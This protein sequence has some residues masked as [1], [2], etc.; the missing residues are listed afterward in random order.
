[1]NVFLFYKKIINHGGA[2]NLLLNHYLDLKKKGNQV[3]ILTYQNHLFKDNKISKDIITVKNI[4]GLIFFLKKFKDKVFICHSGYI[5][6]FFLTLFDKI[7]YSIFLH[8]PTLL[9][10]NETDKFALNNLRKFE[11]DIKL[12]IFKEN[13][14]LYK[15][16]KKKFNLFEK[17]Y[18]NLRYLISRFIIKN[19]NAIFVLSQASKIE[20]KI[21]YDKEAYF[22]RGALKN[23][24]I[25]SEKKFNE[26]NQNLYFCIVS[27][28]DINKRI[29]V[30]LRAIKNSNYHER[31]FLDIF[32]KG[33][34]LEDI[35]KSIKILNLEKNVKYKGFLNEKDKLNTISKYNYFVCLD[36]ADF[37]ISSYES[38]KACTPVILTTETS[39]D[40]DFEGL[41]CL[42]YCAPQ[43]KKI[44]NQIDMLFEENKKMINWKLVEKQLI[45]VT[46]E[47]Y[48]KQINIHAL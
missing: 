28:L 47:N 20:K 27:R 7:K 37:R 33:P 40:K 44:I 2:E 4:F 29:K 19:A 30:F 39:P 15:K 26:N 1:M 31:I 42:I 41:N 43:K 13:M 45:N 5:E 6:I 14:K 36:M 34:Q 24:F 10:F 11:I 23:N 3:K 46:W 18:I 9:S 16:I 35:K 48:F 38:L 22:L 8:Q 32:G 25:V 21:L 17:T 12:N